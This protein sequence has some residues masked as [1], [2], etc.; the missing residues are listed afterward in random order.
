MGC[1][2]QQPEIG[3]E[4][5]GSAGIVRETIT[6]QEESDNTD[7][8]QAAQLSENPARRDPENA[9]L[10]CLQSGDMETL[11]G[12]SF[13]DSRAYF[14]FQGKGHVFYNQMYNLGFEREM[15]YY[16]FKENRKFY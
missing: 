5:T 15:K 12:I 14:F 1:H 6:D 10:L 9:K 13:G 16:E 8:E 7:A 3:E 11:L 2:A 4:E